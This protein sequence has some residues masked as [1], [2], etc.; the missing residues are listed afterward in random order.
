MKLKGGEKLAYNH[1]HKAPWIL[2]ILSILAAIIIATISH[3]STSLKKEITEIP[4]NLSPKFFPLNQMPSIKYFDFNKDFT[5]SIWENC[6]A[7]VPSIDNILSTGSDRT[8]FNLRMI[9]YHG[10]YDRNDLVS[11][12]FGIQNGRLDV[13]IKPVRND[14]IQF[15][16]VK[17]NRN[18]RFYING[19]KVV[20]GDIINH[21]ESGQSITIGK[22]LGEDNQHDYIFHGKIRDLKTFDISLNDNVILNNFNNEL[23][24]IK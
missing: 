1:K 5:I 19:K 4:Q 18:V 2:G 20:E 21:I 23:K 24:L 22:H 17:S 6:N 12:L 8:Y 11:V 3:D 9:T 16:I 15:V 14:W 10:D 7:L 13:A